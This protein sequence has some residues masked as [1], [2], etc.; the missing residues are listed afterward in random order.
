MKIHLNPLLT[1]ESQNRAHRDHPDEPE[2]GVNLTRVCHLTASSGVR[3]AGQSLLIRPIGPTALFMADCIFSASDAS[4]FLNL[5]TRPGQVERIII[6]TF[7]RVT[8]RGQVKSTQLCCVFF[9]FFSFSILSRPIVSPLG[10]GGVG[11][12]TRTLYY[13]GLSRFDPHDTAPCQRP[14]T[15]DWGRPGGDISWWSTSQQRALIGP[16]PSSKRTEPE[17]AALAPVQVSS[18]TGT[19]Q[20]FMSHWEAKNT[21]LNA[22]CAGWQTGWKVSAT[23]WD[24]CWLGVDWCGFCQ[25]W[26][27]Y[28]FYC[29]FK[30]SNSHQIMLKFCTVKQ[31]QSLAS[32]HCPSAQAKV[33]LFYD[34]TIV[35]VPPNNRLAFCHFSVARALPQ[36]SASAGFGSHATPF[37]QRPLSTIL[38][39][40]ESVLVGLGCGIWSTHGIFDELGRFSL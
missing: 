9:F 39:P 10:W 32:L 11:K 22:G 21:L 36:D 25:K 23:N 17:S 5:L 34:T 2:C 26:E 8:P 19:C 18:T 4:P 14:H 33:S 30:A 24:R 40:P 31:F 35:L 6:F 3:S 15:T 37:D 38:L 1:A 7:I 27:F 16:G 13:S 29:Y 28:V 12:K 20:S